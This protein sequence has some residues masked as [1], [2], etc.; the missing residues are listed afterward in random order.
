V[1]FDDEVELTDV[2]APVAVEHRV[3]GALV[4]A[5]RLLLAEPAARLA[6]PI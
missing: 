3:P 6:R 5:R 4:P 1:L 2:T